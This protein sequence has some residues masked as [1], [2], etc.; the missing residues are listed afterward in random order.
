MKDNHEDI[1]A[2]LDLGPRRS[3]VWRGLGAAA[4]ICAALAAV[5]LWHADRGPE[6]EPFATEAATR[7][8]LTVSVI[9]TGTVEPTN[10]VEISSELSG[11]VRAVLVDHND[12]V[13]IGQPLAQLDTARLD[14]QLAHAR[15]AL[16]ARLARVA[17]AEATLREA[18]DQNERVGA[19]ADR[20]VSTA[21]AR[22]AAVANLRR[23]EATVAVTRADAD[24]ARADLLLREA[25]MGKACICSPIRGVVLERNVEPGQI[26]ASSLQAPILFTIAEDLSQMELRVDVDEADMGAVRVGQ[27][28]RFTVE[29]YRGRSFPASI[30]E[31]RYAPKSVDGVVTYEALLHVDNADLLLRPGMTATAEIVVERIDDAL[32]VPNA[33]LRFAPPAPPEARRSGGGLLGLLIPRRPGAA[34]PTAAPQADA[35]GWRTIWVARDAEAAP[36]RVRAG[37]SDGAR[38]AILDGALAPGDRV[39]TDMARP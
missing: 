3:R 23:A 16:A 27:P 20:N 2:A 9:A 22:D 37:A 25:D 12:R 39:I 10:L 19:L 1:D 29:A 5:G 13:E 35:E 31:L 8:P 36:V 24:V 38:T 26:V 14:A 18:T 28:A 21:Q 11:T 32:L 17:E 7:G 30:A 34:G 6:S 15:A 33:A 4:A